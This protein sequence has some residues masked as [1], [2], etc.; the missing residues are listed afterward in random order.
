MSKRPKTQAQSGCCVFRRG[1]KQVD[2]EKS[3][4]SLSFNSLT[5]AMSLL[6]TGERDCQRRIINRPIY[7]L[8]DSPL[9]S[10]TMVNGTICS[11]ES[12]VQWLVRKNRPQQS[13]R[14]AR[15]LSR[16]APLTSLGL[17]II[18]FASLKIY[19]EWAAAEA[20]QKTNTQKSAYQ[21]GR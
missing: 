17:S 5:F 2:G 4:Q 14:R 10:R 16:C 12:C 13:P 9:C 18:D 15:K 19:S 7:P 21:I 20:V 3:Q 6:L 1:L 11:H 8:R